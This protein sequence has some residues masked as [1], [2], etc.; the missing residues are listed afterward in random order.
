MLID[1]NELFPFEEETK[2]YEI[3]FEGSSVNGNEVVESE[4]FTLTVIHH[5]NRQMEMSGCGEIT[6]LIPCARCLDPVETKVP[7]EISRLADV[8]ANKDEEGEDVFFFS[9]D[10]LDTD[11]LILD[12]LSLNIPM[13]VLCKEDCKGICLRCGANLNHG[14][15]TCGDEETET[16]M[17]AALKKAFA[18]AMNKQ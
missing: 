6:L 11:E 8:E 1:L 17:G 15:C 14:K 13:K 4:A 3:F 2:K 5:K 12:E 9:K 18:D 7:F 16:R 10:H